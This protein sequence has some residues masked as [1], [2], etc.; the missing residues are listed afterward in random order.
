M[1]APS[2][3]PSSITSKLRTLVLSGEVAGVRFL[4]TT[5]VFALSEGNLVLAGEKTMPLTILL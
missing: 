3:M 5:A 4:G 1:A 2:P